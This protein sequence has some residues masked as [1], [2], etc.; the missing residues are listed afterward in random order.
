MGTGE[1]S[2]D[3]LKKVDDTK[4]AEFNI[5][6]GAHY[7]VNENIYAMFGYGH[8]TLVFHDGKDNNNKTTEFSGSGTNTLQLG[9]SYHF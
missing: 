6:F 3:K 4:V 1:A 8:D 9:V 2:S 7:Q 5:G